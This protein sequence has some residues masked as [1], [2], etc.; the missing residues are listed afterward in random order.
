MKLSE[1]RRKCLS[2]ASNIELLSA[3]LQPPQ[4]MPEASVLRL[5]AEI[6]TDL[7]EVTAFWT[8]YRAENPAPTAT[9][10]TA[11]AR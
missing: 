10:P 3:A 5:R 6:R 2:V 11:P 8:A 1:L 7:D 9:E 4:C